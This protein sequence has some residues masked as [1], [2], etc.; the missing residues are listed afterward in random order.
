MLA[1]TVAGFSQSG[2]VRGLLFD[3]TTGNGFASVATIW[4]PALEKGTSSDMNGNFLIEEVP[5]GTHQ[6]KIKC[7]GYRDTVMQ[8][9]IQPC[10]TTTITV[11]FPIGCHFRNQ[12]GNVCPY[13]HKNDVAIPIIYGFPSKRMMVLSKKNKLKLAGC[14]T[15]GCDP[16]W[17]CRKDEREF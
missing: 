5:V 16:Q 17:Y 9:E 13:C 4:F 3:K 10:L 7:I 6:L 8:V 1:G 14:Q 2:E 12:N 15:T 11:N